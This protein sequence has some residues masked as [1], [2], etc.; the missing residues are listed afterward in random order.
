MEDFQDFLQTMRVRRIWFNPKGGGID[1]PGYDL[2]FFDEDARPVV[3]MYIT[4]TSYLYCK[5]WVYR[6]TAPSTE[7]V[8]AKLGS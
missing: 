3:E 2:Y 8:W 1:V 4:H 5:P 6:I 7:D